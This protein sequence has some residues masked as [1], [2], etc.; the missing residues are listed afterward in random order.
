MSKI[1]R[2]LQEEGR[3]AREA[4]AQEAPPAFLLLEKCP[5]GNIVGK[6]CLS[7][8]MNGHVW[9][10]KDPQDVAPLA[11]LE[12]C[13]HGNLV[14]GVCFACMLNGHPWAAR[15]GDVKAGRV[16]Q[17]GGDWPFPGGHDEDFV[18]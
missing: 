2:Q 17:Q 5:H 15:D 8:M 3:A 18:P 9:A 7:C 1:M 6:A 10:S 14:G 4:K 16:V 11:P 13:P 12:D